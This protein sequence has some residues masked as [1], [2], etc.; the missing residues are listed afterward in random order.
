MNFLEQD[1]DLDLNDYAVF[2]QETPKLLQDL[3]TFHQ[4]IMAGLQ[5]GEVKFADAM[6]LMLETDVVS[7]IRKFEKMSRKREKE[8]AM[9]Q[10]QQ[11]MALQAQKQQGQLEAQQK[12]NE[13]NA[14][15][16][17]QAAQRAEQLQQ[18]KERGDTTQTLLKGKIDLAKQKIQSVTELEKERMKPKPKPT[19][20]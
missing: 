18:A 16:A 15:T 13:F 2:V 9:M 17:N 1:V 19:A 11:E 5:S 14:Q 4:M 8:A 12:M 6:V 20:K 7:G 10:Q 3:A